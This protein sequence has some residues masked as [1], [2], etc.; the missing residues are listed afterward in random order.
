M[1]L[2][3]LSQATGYLDLL[4]LIRD[5]GLGASIMVGFWLPELFHLAVTDLDAGLSV[6]RE[7]VTSGEQDKIVGSAH[8]LR[9]FDHEIVFSA[10]E[11]IAELLD[12]AA[13][14]GSDCLQHAS[15]ELYAVAVSGIYS[16]SP[17]QP[18]PRHLSDK[19]EAQ[20]LAVVYNARPP[21]RDFYISL[22][23]HAE[24]SIK[25]E[26]QQWDEEGDDE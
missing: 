14:C 26:L 19:T 1:T 11:F 15:S 20:R 3:G 4:R 12:A 23:G 22:V 13:R 18:A 6:L 17:G 25:R 5:A 10:H 9:G 2:P 24:G 21:V 8:F 16:G 7:W